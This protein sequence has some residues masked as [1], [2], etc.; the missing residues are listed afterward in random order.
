MEIGI[1][2][3]LLQQCHLICGTPFELHTKNYTR[4]YHQLLL[5]MTQLTT[6]INIPSI[7]LI[8]KK[9]KYS[10]FQIYLSSISTVIPFLKSTS[11][12]FYVNWHTGA[13]NTPGKCITKKSRK[14]ISFFYRE[15][16]LWWGS[17]EKRSFSQV[18]MKLKIQTMISFVIF[19]S[20][21]FGNITKDTGTPVWKLL[22]SILYKIHFNFQHFMNI[23]VRK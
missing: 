9:R 10:K 21:T 23:N 16:Q 4:N 20:R 13:Y 17:L 19:V 14:K 11:I 3:V 6:L 15:K 7:L 22:N 18:H 5:M 1:E 8:A 12:S 2:K